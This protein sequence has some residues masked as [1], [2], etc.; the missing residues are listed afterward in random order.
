MLSPPIRRSMEDS[1]WLGRSAGG[2]NDEPFRNHRR[3][4]EHVGESTRPELG[5]ILL[6]RRQH[7]GQIGKLRFQ[8]CGTTFQLWRPGIVV[9]IVAKRLH[10]DPDSHRR[11]LSDPFQRSLVERRMDEPEPYLIE[12]L[13]GQGLP[14]MVDP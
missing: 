2:S 8:V 1:L 5:G 7:M 12:V 10:E 9:R 3:P 11:Q 6:V 13:T 4:P 14:G